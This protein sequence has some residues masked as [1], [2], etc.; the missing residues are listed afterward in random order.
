[1]GK[2]KTEILKFKKITWKNK[3]D[4]KKE[5]PVTRTYNPSYL[6]G[7]NQED[8]ESKPAQWKCF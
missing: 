2:V 8:G 5:V 1:M 4:K 7:W 3:F 6:G